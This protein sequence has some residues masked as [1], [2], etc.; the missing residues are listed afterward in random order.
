MRSFLSK[1]WCVRLRSLMRTLVPQVVDEFG[2]VYSR[3]GGWSSYI[4]SLDGPARRSPGLFLFPESQSLGMC[5]TSPS[6]PVLGWDEGA[7][8]RVTRSLCWTAFA[9]VCLQYSWY[10]SVLAGLSSTS[11][12]VGCS[13]VPALL[14][15]CSQVYSHTTPSPSAS[16]MYW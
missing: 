14:Q 11:S 7:L 13:G 2:Q 9:F 5:K 16:R 10:R 15:G 3:L 8:V 4:A 6:A 12:A 1:R